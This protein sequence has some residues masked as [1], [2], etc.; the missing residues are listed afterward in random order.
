MRVTR[1]AAA[2]LLDQ[3]VHFSVGKVERRVVFDAVEVGQERDVIFHIFA[4]T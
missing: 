4:F 3:H 2:E 1:E